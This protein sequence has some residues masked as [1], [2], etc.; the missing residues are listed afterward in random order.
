MPA[1]KKSYLYSNRIR[2]TLPSTR[3]LSRSRWVDPPP[4][5]QACVPVSCLPGFLLCSGSREWSGPRP[6]PGPSAGTCARAPRT[7]HTPAPTTPL[8]LP[9]S[10]A[11]GRLALLSALSSG[12]VFP[13]A[14][15]ARVQNLGC[16]RGVCGPYPAPAPGRVLPTSPSS[17]A[18]LRV[19]GGPRVCLRA[20]AAS[21]CLSHLPDDFGNLSADSFDFMCVSKICIS[22]ANLSPNLG[23]LHC[24]LASP[25]SQVASS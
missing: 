3:Q 21:L 13:T 23:S 22:S 15:E 19:P 1:P 10:C 17:W 18:P 20:H 8:R 2:V 14:P 4:L 7:D 16:H 6:S 25:D 9:S 24:F 5:L 11:P 12:R